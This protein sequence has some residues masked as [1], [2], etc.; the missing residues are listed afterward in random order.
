MMT[1][2][3]LNAACD[4]F[5]SQPQNNQQQMCPSMSAIQNSKIDE[6]LLDL[7][8][9]GSIKV[10]EKIN[11]SHD[12]I[13]INSKS[14]LDA[15]SRWLRGE[16][17]TKN[18]SFVKLRINQTFEC[19]EIAISE[20]ERLNKIIP[21]SQ[22]ENREHMVMKLRNSQFIERLRLGLDEAS[23]GIKNI[24]QTY[25]QDSRTFA[26]VALLQDK[27]LDYLKQIDL[28]LK[29]ISRTTDTSGGGTTSLLSTIQNALN[30]NGGGGGSSNKLATLG[31]AQVPPPLVPPP[32]P[33]AQIPVLPPV[34]PPPVILS[35]PPTPQSISVES[36]EPPPLPAVVHKSATNKKGKA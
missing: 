6:L 26:F 31:L 35:A 7:K 5:N 33:Q 20:Q 16:N 23:T 8:I 18:I 22:K 11:T 10:D 19:I 14:F 17:R 4:A 3:E 21:M 34:L 27:I 2:H 12:V 25:Q 36:A 28:S 30:A 32:V 9:I 15:L 29:W 1:S 24:G 13:D